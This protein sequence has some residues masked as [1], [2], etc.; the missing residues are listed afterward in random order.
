[1]VLSLVLILYLLLDSFLKH[2]IPNHIH[3]SLRLRIHLSTHP[4]PLPSS[5]A[6]FETPLQLPTW[7]DKEC[8]F[9]LYILHYLKT[10]IPR[11][12]WLH[13]PRLIS[14]Q[15]LEELLDLLLVVVLVQGEVGLEESTEKR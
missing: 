11:L 15:V 7:L 14:V 4:T 1:L 5:E 3:A 13:R 2:L 6:P 10:Q 8:P 12:E 9:P